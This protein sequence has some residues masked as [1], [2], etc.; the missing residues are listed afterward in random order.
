MAKAL[1]LCVVTLHSADCGSERVGVAGGHCV[2]GWRPEQYRL[3]PADETFCSGVLVVLS[4]S[5]VDNTV[6]AVL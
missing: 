2:P 6:R 1:P 4:A 3:H 5:L